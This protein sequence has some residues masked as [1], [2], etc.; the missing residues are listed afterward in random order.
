MQQYSQEEI[1]LVMKLDKCTQEE[2]INKYCALRRKYIE[3]SK[4]KYELEQKLNEAKSYLANID[5]K[6]TSDYDQDTTDIKIKRTEARVFLRE[7]E[8][9]N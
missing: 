7:N 5:F 2:A 8:D 9:G 3:K 1:E 4:I 6:M